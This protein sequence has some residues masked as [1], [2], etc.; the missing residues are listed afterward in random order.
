MLL[1]LTLASRYLWGRKLRTFLTTLAVMFGVLVIF[2]MNILIPTLL[3]AFEGNLRAASHQVDVTVT[4]K[5][6]ESFSASVLR[7]VKAVDGVQAAAGSLNRTLNVPDNFYGRDVSLSAVSLVGIDPGSAQTIRDYSLKQGR[8]LRS[9]DTTAALI[10]LSLAEQVK[11]ALGDTL[12]LP[13]AAGAVKLKVVGL[14]PAR[15]LPGNEEVLVSLSEAQKLLDLPDRINTIEANLDTTDPARRAVIQQALEQYLGNNYQLGALSSGGELL[16]SFQNGQTAFNLMGVMALFMGGF[17]IFNT[18]R[19]IVAERRHDIGMLRAL[20]A[21]RGAILGMILIEGVLQGVAGTLAG[22]AMGYLL[23]AGILALISPIYAQLLHI[24]TG[25]PII[26]PSLVVTSVMLGVGVTLVAG[27][28]PALSASRVTPLEALRPSF[29]ESI[30]AALGT[31]SLVGAGLIGFAGIVLFSK[32]GGLVALGGV[33]LLVGLVLVAPAL[34]RPI[35]V[36]F[37]GLLTILFATEGTGTLAEGNLTRQTSRAAVTASAIM[38]GIAIIVALGGMISSLN[39]FT[40]GI[41]QKTLGSDYLLVPPSIATWAGNVGASRGLADKLREVRGVGVVNTMRYAAST[42]NGKAV[43]LL[44]IDPVFYPRASGLDF[45]EGDPTTAYTALGA[46]HSL[47]VNG[48][49]AANAGLKTGDIVRLSTPDGEQQY[50]VVAVAGD[51]VNFKILTAYIS[52]ANME[53]QFHKSE[54]VFIQINLA[55]GAVATDVEP[56]L[57]AIVKDY[58]QFHFIAG[59]VYRDDLMQQTQSA[60]AILYILLGVLAVPSLIALLNTLAIGVIER[61][62]EIGMLRAIGAT[63]GQVRRM[64]V[65]ESLLLAGI[66]TAFGLVAGIYLG[67]VMVVGLSAAGLRIPYSFP[68]AGLLSAVATG[69]VFGVLAALLPARQAARLE[70]IRA[71]HYE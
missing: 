69:M 8:F 55:P 15:T 19:T 47:I 48:L 16:A 14:L 54:D 70:I 6:G 7:K 18:F 37:G 67:D 23:G 34:I 60:Y 68:A 49:L 63:Q 2:G 36:V 66:G 12:S 26:D 51:Y 17:I 46:E 65:A 24:K 4:E 58:P 39:D 42:V 5:T 41:M 10:T 33:A 9:E 59:K 57:R 30:G 45:L 35:A 38:I 56:R 71:L 21:G 29:T 1:Q 52:Q 40:A 32:Q 20:G 50:R 13:T 44:G 3:D 28:L 53:A 62:R 31:G 25:T 61:T 64:V 11:L 43:S 22:L 27:L